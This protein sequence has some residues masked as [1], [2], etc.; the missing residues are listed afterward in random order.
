MSNRQRAFFIAMTEDKKSKEEK[1][2]SLFWKIKDGEAEP[3]GSQKGWKNLNPDK[4]NLKT[5]DPEK[6]KEIRR[7]GA[8]AINKLH[9]E[10]KTAKQSLEQILTLK[11]DDATMNAADLPEDLKQKIKRSNPD[12]TLY[13]LIQLVAAGRAI[14][15]NI[16]AA[17]YIR[18]THGD[19]PV[20]QLEITDATTEADREMMRQLTERLKNGERIEVV[21]DIGPAEDQEN[22]DVS[23]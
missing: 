17:E 5:M 3:V 23:I 15:G 14:G 16:R 11:I 22:N 7:K 13:D 1:E 9:G 8:E 6:A 21:K 10:K 20:K 4:Y 18:D 2:K 12:A 19:Q